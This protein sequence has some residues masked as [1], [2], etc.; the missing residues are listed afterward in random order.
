MSYYISLGCLL[1]IWSLLYNHHWLLHTY[2]FY[3][4]SLSYLNLSISACFPNL[5]RMYFSMITVAICQLVLFKQIKFLV[6]I[7]KMFILYMR[8]INFYS[9]P[10]IRLHYPSHFSD[11]KVGK[12]CLLKM[13]VYI[14]I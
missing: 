12:Y 7:P 5:N 9:S 13:C 10:F 14:Y 2:I 1:R 8:A 6:D 4:L 11:M 3:L